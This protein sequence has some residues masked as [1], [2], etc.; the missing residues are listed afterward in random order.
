MKQNGSPP[1]PLRVAG[2]FAVAEHKVGVAAHGKCGVRSAECG[3]GRQSL[4]TSA[5]TSQ[6]GFQRRAVALHY[7]PVR[8]GHGLQR[9][10]G[11][12]SQDEREVETAGALEHRAAA[13]TATQD[14]R[15]EEH[16]SE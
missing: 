13:A 1:P 11:I 12:N 10:V 15:S 6:Q 16:T 3:V 5:A 8:A 2:E 9:R 7:E 14:R 4:L